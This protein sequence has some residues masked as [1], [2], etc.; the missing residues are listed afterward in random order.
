MVSVSS[1]IH[2]FYDLSINEKHGLLGTS[3]FGGSINGNL[4]MVLAA[5]ELDLMNQEYFLIRLTN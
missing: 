5:L 4:H 3:G 2:A 1:S